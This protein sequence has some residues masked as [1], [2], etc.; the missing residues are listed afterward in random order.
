MPRRNRLARPYQP[1]HTYTRLLADELH[2]LWRER[3]AALSSQNNP[4]VPQQE[5][6]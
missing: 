4:F 6:S 5:A 3:R 1:R 2:S